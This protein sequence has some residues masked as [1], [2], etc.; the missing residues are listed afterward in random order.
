MTLY[1][2]YNAPT[3][4]EEI[5]LADKAYCSNT[6]NLLQLITPYKRARN[7]GL[8]NI[9]LRSNELHSFYRVTVEHAIGYLKRFNILSN[10][11]RGKI[12]TRDVPEI[13]KVLKIIIN[14]NYL[15]TSKYPLRSLNSIP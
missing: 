11:Y 12:F 3:T 4:S 2:S 7:R 1:R 9:Q 6:S 13:E 8:T 10:R 14:L 5:I 15:Y